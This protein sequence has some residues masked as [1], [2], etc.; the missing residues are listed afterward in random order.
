MKLKIKDNIELDL[1]E[2]QIKDLKRQLETKEPEIPE[3]TIVECW[4]DGD[5]DRFLRR[6][7]FFMRDK[8]HSF[9]DGENGESD[10]V[11][12][13]DHVKPLLDPPI[14]ELW[15]ATDKDGC[16]YGY[17]VK[18]SRLD[19]SYS[20]GGNYLELGTN[21]NNQTFEDGPQKVE[22]RLVGE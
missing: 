1:T 12:P 3:G 5:K 20:G 21:I 14:A 4:D 19:A 10:R 11:V 15:M 16:T 18:P 22:L 13:W 6:Y 2:D 8:H 7:A 9:F 17:T